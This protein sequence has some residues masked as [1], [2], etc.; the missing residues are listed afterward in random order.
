M[1][2]GWAGRDEKPRREQDWMSELTKSREPEFL[3]ADAINVRSNPAGAPEF[4]L[5]WKRALQMHPGVAGVTAALVFAAVFGFGLITPKQY[6]A[7]AVFSVSPVVTTLVPQGGIPGTMD[8]SQFDSSMQQDVETLQREDTVEAAIKTLPIGAWRKPNESVVAAAQRMQRGLGVSR[9]GTSLQIAAT[10]SGPTP[11]DAAQGLAAISAQF[12]K[13]V[14]REEDGRATER[15][16]LLKEESARL[17]SNLQQDRDAAAELAGELGVSRLRENERTPADMSADQLR[18]QLAELR[19]ARAFAQ[20][21]ISTSQAGGMDDAS[22][23]GSSVAGLVSTLNI[24]K[25]ALQSQ[26]AGMTARNPIYQMNAAE[27]KAIDGE[28]AS[29][30]SRGDA[31]QLRRQEQLR[32][33]SVSGVSEEE[34]RLRHQLVQNTSGMTGIAAKLEHYSELS[35][36]IDRLQTRLGTVRDAI[37]STLLQSSAPSGVNLVVPPTDTDLQ[38][39]GKRRMAML[40]ALPLALLAGLV[41][42]IFAYRRDGRVFLAVD[43]ESVLG[44]RPM[45]VLPAESEVSDAIAEQ[46]LLRMAGSIESAYLKNR[47]KTFVFT[48]TSED[49]DV[50]ELVFRVQGKL[51]D[52]G[53]SALW[54]GAE[55]LLR[56]EKD[57]EQMYGRGPSSG[58]GLRFSDAPQADGSVPEGIAIQRLNWLKR[59][60]DMVLIDAPPLLQSALAEY[61]VRRTDATILVSESGVTTREELAQA[62]GLLEQLGTQGIGAVLQEMH[63]RYAAPGYKKALAKAEERAARQVNREPVD[64]AGAWQVFNAGTMDELR[65]PGDPMARSMARVRPARVRPQVAGPRVS[66]GEP[67]SEVWDEDSA[68]LVDEA[69]Y[70]FHRD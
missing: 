11:K 14:H 59:D 40:A 37:S 42:A 29:A 30:L 18:S 2:A 57:F 9:V 52:L 64:N 25:A 4:R 21:G 16:E 44:I 51:R 19:R 8:V 33:R 70:S 68:R 23:N 66:A 43:L 28:L 3:A 1:H 6:Q 31:E 7:K 65:V 27:L 56:A 60:Y 55:T 58:S 34:Q 20:A 35:H 48:A 39:G 12:L 50:E 53:Y 22:N 13:T 36:E 63:M 5:N 47:S 38:A 67:K 62:S 69:A 46:G 41:A 24:R 17:D 49:S 10:L 45:A 61:A 32:N 54:L 15:V 26:M